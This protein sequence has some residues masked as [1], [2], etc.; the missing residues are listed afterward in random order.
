MFRWIVDE[1]GDIGLE[2]CRVLKIFKYKHS[3]LMELNL[4]RYERAPKYVRK[5]G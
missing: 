3:A 5:E 2:I 4:K 1:E